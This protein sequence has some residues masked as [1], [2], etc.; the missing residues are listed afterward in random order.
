[1]EFHKVL[2]TGG[3][4][5]KDCCGTLKVK[6][7]IEK[8]QKQVELSRKDVILFL[9]QWG[10]ALSKATFLSMTT[11]YTQTCYVEVIKEMTGSFG[12]RNV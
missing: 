7:V 8:L 2:V 6:S 4:A 10:N 3:K 9:S 11:K 5:K 12:S 1:M